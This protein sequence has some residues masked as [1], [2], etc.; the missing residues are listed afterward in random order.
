MELSNIAAS[1]PVWASILAALGILSAWTPAAAH[2]H[3]WITALVEPQFDEA[4]RWTAVREKWAF[5]YDYSAIVGPQLDQDGDGAV[6]PTVLADGGAL[7][8]IISKDFLT[9]LTIAG[10]EVA[11]GQ[12]T[13]LSIGVVGAKLL[14]EFT[15][16]IAEPQVITLGAGVDVFDPE[17]YYDVAFDYPDI[18]SP[19]APRSCVV[20]RRQQPNLDPTAVMLIRRLGLSVDPAIL[21]DPATGFAVR[22]AIDCK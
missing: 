11:R 18:E 12:P 15:L 21:G 3:V 22:V 13:S 7:S 5:D 1:R 4:G 20:D 8:W 2:P 19:T 17:V 16:P 9:R 6:D 14:I 10:R